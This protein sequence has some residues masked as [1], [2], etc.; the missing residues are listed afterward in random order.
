MK[1]L[2]V[3]A[4]AARY[5]GNF[6]ASMKALEGLLAQQGIETAYLLPETARDMPW[7]R[8]LQGRAQVYFAGL[9]RF[10]PKVYTQ[11]KAAMADAD[12]VHSHFELYD[13]LTALAKRKGQKLFW[14]LHDSFDEVI[15]LPHRLINKFQYGV[16][17]RKAVLISP[18]DYY[19]AMAAD[20]GFP[21]ERICHVDN[22]VEF[23]RL[24]KE[25]REKEYDFLVFGGFYR[26]KGLDVLMDACRILKEKGTSFRLGVVGYPDTWDFLEG[27]YPDLKENIQRLEPSEDVS[28]FYNAAG[29]FICASRRECF[30]YAVL[31]A[32]YMEKAVIASRIPGNAWAAD[33]ETVTSF[34]SEDAPALADAMKGNL[35]KQPDPAA[36]AAVLEDIQKRYS[37]RTWALAIKEIY[38]GTE[39]VTG[40]H[41]I[42]PNV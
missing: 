27:N 5:G 25:E 31:E 21:K 3:C 40:N 8:E 23:S 14:H 32:L 26:I 34:P 28:G 18:N 42:H 4:Y 12:V 24:K 29:G 20:W 9:N 6:M 11:V 36:A 30:S 2:Q 16:L 37:A 19:S 38:F 35:T 39:T 13:C 17:G 1:V 15:D 41:G 22:A 10:S 7:C 33:Y